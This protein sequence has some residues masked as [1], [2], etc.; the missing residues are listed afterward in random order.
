MGK[1]YCQGNRKA[2]RYRAKI[3]AGNDWTVYAPWGKPLF[4]GRGGRPPFPPPGWIYWENKFG[5]GFIS[6]ESIATPYDKQVSTDRMG[7]KIPPEYRKLKIVDM[8]G[9][10]K[11]R[12]GKK[13]SLP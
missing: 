4:D 11:M 8:S 9:G 7:T 12:H 13:G 5:R 10:D 1:K 6:H 2:Q 3:R